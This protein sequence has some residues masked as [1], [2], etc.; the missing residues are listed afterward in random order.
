MTIGINQ[1]FSRI[2]FSKLINCVK[3]N[4]TTYTFTTTE[5]E[6]FLFTN[7]FFHIKELP[8]TNNSGQ[9]IVV[10]IFCI[11]HA[12]RYFNFNKIVTLIML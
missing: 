6:V 8:H 11:T 9:L 12:S 10:L 3:N 1:N 5:F 4:Q 2:F 7:F